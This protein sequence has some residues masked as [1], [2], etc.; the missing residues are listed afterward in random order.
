MMQQ[1]LLVA[2]ARWIKLTASVLA[3]AAARM[4][5]CFN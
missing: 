3:A 5:H 1:L 4:T 2:A